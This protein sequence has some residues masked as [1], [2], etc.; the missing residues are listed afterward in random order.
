VHQVFTLPLSNRGPFVQCTGW[1]G[2]DA[3]AAQFTSG[4]VQRHI[5]GSGHFNLGSSL[6]EGQCAVDL[7]F[8]AD[9]YAP[10]AANTLVR[11]VFDRLIAGGIVG[12]RFGRRHT[13]DIIAELIFVCIFLQLAITV[14]IAGGT[15]T[16]MFI[17]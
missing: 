16:A 10:S 12:P 2:R 4:I 3:L 15:G 9:S 14:I 8:F 17:E 11:I 13:Q 1:T 6:L 5:K 7:N